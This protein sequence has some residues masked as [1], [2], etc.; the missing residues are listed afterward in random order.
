MKNGIDPSYHLTERDLAYVLGIRTR[1]IKRMVRLELIEP[2]GEAQEPLFSPDV[3]VRVQRF[4]RLH[5]QLGVSWS[6]MDLV[7][8][9]LDRIDRLERE[10][11]RL[12]REAP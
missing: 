6:S 7:V 3:V 12:K 11:N 1:M 9:L 8:E 2:V 5:H 10:L 4:V